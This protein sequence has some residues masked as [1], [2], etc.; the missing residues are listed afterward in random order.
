[1]LE[2]L[3]RPPRSPPASS[4]EPQ[5][6]SGNGW[7]TGAPSG[8]SPAP[9]GNAPPSPSPKDPFRIGEL[10]WVQNVRA[11]LYAGPALAPLRVGWVCPG[12][13]FPPVQRGDGGR[14]R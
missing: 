9:S 10:G 12:T 8:A 1:M 3:R 14:G 4:V 11:T 2:A 5:A 13:P 7:G 6:S